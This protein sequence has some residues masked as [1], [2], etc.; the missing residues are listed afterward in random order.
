LAASLQRQLPEEDDLTA[1]RVATL[2][3]TVV[4]ISKPDPNV[5]AQ[6]PKML[7]ELACAAND[8]GGTTLYRKPPATAP[9]LS[10]FACVGFPQIP[11]DD[12]GTA[13][14]VQL[15]V[16]SGP[17]DACQSVNHYI[18]SCSDDPSCARPWYVT[19]PPWW[20]CPITP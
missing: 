20:P 17:N 18:L 8:A 13:S 6:N 5:L 11:G 9:D 16:P 14:G 3:Q 15:V 10:V 12:A 7:A 1:C 2:D 19:P 4:T